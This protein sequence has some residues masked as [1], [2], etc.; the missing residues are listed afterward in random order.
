MLSIACIEK[1]YQRSQPLAMLL[2]FPQR[3]NRL[4]DLLFTND[5]QLF[6][7]CECLP[8]L[9]QSDH[10]I[11]KLGIGYEVKTRTAK[12]IDFKR[13]DYNS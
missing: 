7:K 2:D 4:I 5:V 8:P 12:F 9:D 6:T 13:F 3:E 1:F 10:V 11:I